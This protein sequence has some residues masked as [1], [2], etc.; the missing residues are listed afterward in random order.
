MNEKLILESYLDQEV[1]IVKPFDGP[2]IRFSHIEANDDG[3]R[4]Y[5]S[6]MKHQV[7]S[8]WDR[9]N[10]VMLQMPTGTGKTVVFTSIVRDIRKWC[11]CNS[12][13]SKILIIAHRKELIEQASNKLRNL[14][15]GIIQSGKP[16]QL[17]LPVQVASIQ[18]F[19][20]RRNY[21]TMRLQRF[22]FIIIDEA[23]HSMAPGYQKLWDMFPNSKKLGVTA[24]PWRM[25]HS[26]F[27]S[28]F[29]DIVL[30][31]SIEWF[32]NNGYLS[33][34]D[35]I[36]IARNSEI[37]HKINSIDR[38]GADGDYLEAEL[39]NLF[40]KDK[41]RAELYKSY[42]QYAKGKK[43]IIYAIDRKHAANIAELYSVNGVKACMIDGTTPANER[44]ELI[45][46]FKAGVIEVIVNVNIFSEGFDCPDIEFIQLARP[47]KSLALYLQQVGRALRISPN[48][49]SSIILDNVGL[50]NR[51]GTPMANRRWHYHFVGHDEGEGFNDG[52]G[53]TRD[54]VFDPQERIPDYSE[55][56]EAMVLVEH[57]NGGKQI[58]TEEANNAVALGEYNIFRKNGL[59]GICDHKNR[60]LVPPVYEDMH[61]YYSGY[62]PF[63][64]NGKWG[65]MLKN[66][67]IKVKPKYF[68]IGPFIEGIAE[69][70]NR[71]NDPIYHINDKL[72][73]IE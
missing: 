26:G 35:Y 69:V 60:T 25:S 49:T 36:S 10:N 40:D 9:I 19:M 3:L 58:R 14:P 8:L 4:P 55:G 45:E 53:I 63:K 13:E 56:N 73:R 47:T 5:Q 33:N 21:E 17:L 22:D 6:E 24:T 72:E 43:G 28:L 2:T 71:E 18:T 38:Y 51:F 57:T 27:T 1:E 41:I 65:I 12:K 39:S 20:S 54:I 46:S 29:G 37:Q 34:Y 70:Q 68:Y 30:S 31:R 67:T 66:G 15:H 64:Q 42:K 52:S 62:I 44:Q 50:Y 7:Y 59:Y 23:H 61:P 48:K 11:Q 32:V 16:Q